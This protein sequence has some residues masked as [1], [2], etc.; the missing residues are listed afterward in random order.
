MLR[1]IYILR[2]NHSLS[3][4]ATLRYVTVVNAAHHAIGKSSRTKPRSNKQHQ[5]ATAAAP[6]TRQQQQPVLAQEQS[7]H[8]HGYNET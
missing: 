2:H 7:R 4:C 3:M 8:K 1:P 6:C 5:P